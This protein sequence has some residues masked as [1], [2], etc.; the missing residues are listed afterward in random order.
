MNPTQITLICA[1]V[2]AI[3]G[4]LSMLG[5]WS[6]NRFY[7]GKLTGTVEGHTRDIAEVKA[8]QVRMRDDIVIN[9]K[10]IATLQGQQLNGAPVA[11]KHHH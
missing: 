2:G 11:G 9:S 10:D 5:S 4:I 8:E 1:V 6:T 7:Y 3:V